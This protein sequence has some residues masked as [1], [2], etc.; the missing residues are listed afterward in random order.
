MT[1]ARSEAGTVIEERHEHFTIPPPPAPTIV[2]APPPPAVVFAPAPP[3]PAPVEIIRDT[4]II[5]HGA[6]HYER[7]LPQGYERGPVIHDAAPREEHYAE[8]R[9]SFVEHSNV[10]PSAALALVPQHHRDQRSIRDEIKALEAEKEALKAEKRAQH[11]LRKADRIR[12]GG[13][14]HSETDLV[15]Y[16][17]DSYREDGEEYTVV[18]KEKIVRED[19]G[20]VK[21]QKDKKGRMSISVPK[22]YR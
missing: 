14:R 5:E 2:Q 11:E 21:I 13:A 22:Y 6:P 10:G 19:D 16:E 7:P 15:L 17:R 12:R 9:R 8:R 20:G 3:P 18:R 1:R 4:K